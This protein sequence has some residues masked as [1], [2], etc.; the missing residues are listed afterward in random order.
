MTHLCY[1]STCRPVV[2]IICPQSNKFVTGVKTK[3]AGASK[4]MA[5]ADLAGAS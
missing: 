2:D 1:W 3:A 4:L 5:A